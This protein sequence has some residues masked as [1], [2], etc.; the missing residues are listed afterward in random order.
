M[1]IDIIAIE[2]RLAEWKRMKG[3]TTSDE[4]SISDMYFDTIVDTDGENVATVNDF[5][6]RE[7]GNRDF[8]TYAH[9]TP[10]EDD[11]QALLDYVEMLEGRV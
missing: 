9:N 8:I 1:P 11:V 6:E 7:K 4:W 5:Q 2:A 10:I 3:E